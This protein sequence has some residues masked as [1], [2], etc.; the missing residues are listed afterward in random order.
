MALCV[1]RQP[2]EELVTLLA[3]LPALGAGVCFIDDD[4]FGAKALEGLAAALGL[5]VVQADDGE[6][7]GVKQRGTG[8]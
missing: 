6:G 8:W 5:D 1:I 3:A 7:M 2:L 4:E